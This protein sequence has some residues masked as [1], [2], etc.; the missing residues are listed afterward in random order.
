MRFIHLFILGSLIVLLT[1]CTTTYIFPLYSHESFQQ[2]KP[3]E[4]WLVYVHP[5]VAVEDFKGPVQ[6]LYPGDFDMQKQLN[7]QLVDT[8]RKLPLKPIDAQMVRLLKNIDEGISTKTLNRKEL[9]ANDTIGP[10][11]LLR[12][13]QVKIHKEFR[14]R[15]YYNMGYG[16]RS[17]TEVAVVSFTVDLFDLHTNQLAV[18]FM[19]KGEAEMIFFDYVNMLERA[20]ARAVSYTRRFLLDGS[21][22]F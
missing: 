2:M 13:S 20:Q 14:S 8:L 12:V 15:Y 10:R 16:G 21:T 11:Y 22:K 3:N 6:K 5:S 19:T 18:S 9:I 4:R 7:H 1:S 17:V